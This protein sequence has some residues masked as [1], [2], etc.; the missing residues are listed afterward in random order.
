MRLTRRFRSAALAAAGVLGTTS[1]LL[2]ASCTV[3]RGPFLVSLNRAP[4]TPHVSAPAAR[5]SP[6][7]PALQ[8]Q[9]L[10]LH[11]PLGA[12]SNN[13]GVWKLLRPVANADAT[14][15]LLAANG[16]R[17]GLAPFTAWK[18]I[19]QLLNRPGATHQRIY[20]QLSA[21]HPV[22]LTARANVRREIVAWRGLDGGLTVRTYQ[23]C[24]NVF[25][26]AAHVRP[27]SSETIVQLE[28][29]VDLGTV[30]FQRGPAALG[31]VAGVQPLQHVFSTMRI[32]AAIPP[33]Y[34]LLLA[35]AAARRS[36]LSLAARF[37]TQTRRVPQRETVLVFV[38][39]GP[40]G[41]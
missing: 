34:F 15:A 33:H 29:A 32:D 40:G 20:C 25:L 8:V 18:T 41:P 37:L 5:A 6:F 35:P 10:V 16:F 11:L 1:L 13:P 24:D 4:P 7:P 2:L 36:A 17:A 12:C 27:D 28:P 3:K 39:V 21:I 26:L 22:T 19:A 9:V 14:T 23:D 38:P 30:A 31:V